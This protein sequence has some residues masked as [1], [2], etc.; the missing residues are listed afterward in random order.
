MSDIQ[1]V[2]SGFGEYRPGL[3]I[4]PLRIISM[5]EQY[6]FSVSFKD[7]QLHNP[8]KHPNSEEFY[9]FLKP[10]EDIIGI[11]VI[12][13]ALPTVLG[14]VALLKEEHPDKTV[15]LGGPAPTDVGEK[16]LDYFPVD[17]IVLGEGEKTIVEVMEA[18]QGRKPLDQIKGIVCKANGRTVTTPRRERIKDLDSLPLP[19][20]HHVNYADYR[21]LAC[22]MTARGCP[23]KC[24]FCSAHSIW[25][26]KM[27]YR[28][29]ENIVEEILL[30]EDKSVMLGFLDDTFVQ[31]KKRAMAL[32][33]AF[34]KEGVDIPYTC[35]GKITL[36]DDELLTKLSETECFQ[37]FYGVESGSNRILNLLQKGHT[38]EQA[39]EVIRKTMEYDIKRVRT[40]YIWGYP[41]ATLEEFYDTLM[42]MG[43]DLRLEK[44]VTQMSLLSPLPSSPIFK[45]Y[46][47]LIKFDPLIQSRAGG[48]PIQQSLSDYPHIIELIENHPYIFTSFYHYDHPGFDEK[49]QTISKIDWRIWHVEDEATLLEKMK[50][51]EEGGRRE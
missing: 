31:D 50:V 41:F 34:R 9:N 48:L 3:P 26:R 51:A 19:A 14:A 43:E 39:R 33:D 18:L 32:V 2:N 35:N 28:S 37:I 8:E 11:S 16:I 17:I 30:V 20:Y 22:I 45:E 47:Q 44:T 7:Y 4:G 5:L 29:I 36:M 21:G 40:S 38:I 25:Q 1:V 46:H 42:S 15:I 6:G 24:G 27:E 12:C 49:L 23:F 13:N 10:L